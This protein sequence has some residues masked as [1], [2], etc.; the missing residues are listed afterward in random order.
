MRTTCRPRGSAPRCGLSSVLAASRRTVVMCAEALWWR[1]HRRLIA[2]ALALR[3]H[4]VL[5][6]GSD[7]SL[8]EHVLTPF[9]E[10]HDG[11]VTYPPTEPQ[12]PVLI[13]I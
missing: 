8:S 6:I 9:A 12:L 1:C 5:H 4:R 7:G 11:T 2:D 13:F 10:V 3:G